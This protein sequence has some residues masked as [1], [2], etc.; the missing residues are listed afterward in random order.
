MSKSS[1][2]PAF[3]GYLVPVFGWLYVLVLRRD[4]EFA[5]FHAK[6]SLTLTILAL[7]ASL[8]WAVFAWVVLWLP[9]VGPLLAAAAFS[10]LMLAYVYL[11]ALWVVGMVNALRARRQPLPLV[12]GWA[13]R[14][15]IA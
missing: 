10:L 7:A 2:T 15:P 4:D 11:A 1:R 13:E 8:A 12:G 9:T 5:V 6:Q 3:L 14:I